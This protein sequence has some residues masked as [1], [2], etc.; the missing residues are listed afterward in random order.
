M[1]FGF[2]FD[3]YYSKV[4][5]SDANMAK[6]LELGNPS[7]KNFVKNNMSDIAPYDWIESQLTEFTN[8]L[9]NKEKGKATDRDIVTF[10]CKHESFILTAI[11]AI[12]KYMNLKFFRY[13][14]PFLYS[15][16]KFLEVKEAQIQKI[17]YDSFEVYRK[18]HISSSLITEESIVYFYS[19]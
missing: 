9:V 17:K 1:S 16:Q 18:I 5:L 7:F 14:T 4:C 11:N 2:S 8:L 15:Y 12:L 13:I 6:L 10:L 3:K 19:S